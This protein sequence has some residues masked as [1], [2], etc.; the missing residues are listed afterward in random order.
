M[1]KV[2]R[3]SLFNDEVLCIFFS[4]MSKERI[5]ISIYRMIKIVSHMVQ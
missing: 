5:V 3:I 1:K 2:E 4:I